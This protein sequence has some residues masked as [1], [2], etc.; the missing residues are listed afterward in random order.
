MNE[1][2]FTLFWTLSAGDSFRIYQGV[3]IRKEE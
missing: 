2:L 1:L 3:S